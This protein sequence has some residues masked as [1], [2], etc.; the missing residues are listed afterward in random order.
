LGV[1]GGWFGGGV[2]RLSLSRSENKGESVRIHGQEKRPK[3]S[4]RIKKRGRTKKTHGT[5]EKLGQPRSRNVRLTDI[6]GGREER[7]LLPDI[8]H[9]RSKK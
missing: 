3:Y 7:K 1:G 9:L 2:F 6:R 8:V 4:N 5:R